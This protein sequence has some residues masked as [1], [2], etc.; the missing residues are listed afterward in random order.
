[1]LRSVF[2]RANQKY[3]S[4]PLLGPI[5]RWFCRLARLQWLHSGLAQAGDPS[6]GFAASTVSSQQR[7]AQGSLRHLEETGVALRT[8]R[9][10]H[11]ESYIAKAGTRLNRASLQHDI[12][13]LRGFLRF[14]SMDDRAPACRRSS[15]AR[16]SAP[17]RLRTAPQEQ[18]RC[19]Q[20]RVPVWLLG[21]SLEV[22]AQDCRTTWVAERL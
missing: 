1:M 17:N 22:V 8:I 21:G 9:T 10:S 13:A 2:P 7:T 4:R 15:R 19:G 20:R 16:R 14:L 6:S 11:I 3:F 12:G 5:R 18:A